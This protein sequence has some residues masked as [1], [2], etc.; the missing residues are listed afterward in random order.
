MQIFITG[1]SGFLG[2]HLIP[3]LRAEG[4]ELTLL[5]RSQQQA[6]SLQQA[7]IHTVVGSLDNI[8]DWQDALA[9][10]EAIIHLAAPL[11]FWGRWRTMKQAIAEATVHLYRAADQHQVKRFIH[12]S[13]ESVLQNEKPLLDIDESFPYQDPDSYYGRAKQLAEE[14][15][16]TENGDTECIILRPTCIWGEG[17]SLLDN[18]ATKINR[19]QFM[20]ID[21]GDTV[22]ETVHVKNVVEAIRLSLRSGRNKNI[23]FVTDENPQTVREFFTK[24]LATK[25][26]IP[27][28]KNLPRWLG[29]MLA[30]TIEGLWRLLFLP[31]TPPLTHFE[32][33][34]VALPRRYRIDKIKQDMGYEPVISE[35]EGL[36]EMRI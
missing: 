18:V 1:G 5:V 7:G 25:R 22:I 11:D 24:L 4:H 6:E 16:L 8:A 21:N 36:A 33:S 28:E 15:L 10:Q 20:W 17:V 2:R 9:G 26:I 13:S 23:Y 34:F 32:W 35:A 14:Y 27:P 12:I 31:G 29:R 3:V 30:K 19:G